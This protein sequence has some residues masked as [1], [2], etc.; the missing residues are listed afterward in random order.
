MV[1]YRDRI[2]VGSTPTLRYTLKDGDDEVDLTLAT[3]LEGKLVPPSGGSSSTPTPVQVS[4]ELSVVDIPTT[5][6]SFDIAGEW[7]VAVRV[8]FPGS[9]IYEFT[10]DKIHVDASQF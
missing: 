3:L 7:E 10:V 5:T 4:G 6:S 1:D 2:R 9:K 8:T